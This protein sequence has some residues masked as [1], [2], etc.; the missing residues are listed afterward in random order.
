M[1]SVPFSIQDE[2][3]IIDGKVQSDWGYPHS[4]NDE[5]LNGN[6]GLEY[7]WEEAQE[8]GFESNMEYF[9]SLRPHKEP[10]NIE[11]LEENWEFICKKVYNNDGYYHFYDTSFRRVE[12][13]E[14]KTIVLVA[15]AYGDMGG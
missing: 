8:L 13:K 9:V 7:V 3:V 12:V 2:A 1:N 5:D 10:K 11:Q 15:T 4:E 6:N 14:T